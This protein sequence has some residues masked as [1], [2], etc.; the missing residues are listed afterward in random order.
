MLLGDVLARFDDEALAAETILHIGDLSLISKLREQA[1]ATGE[2]LG[3]YAASAMRRYAADA[4]DEE[5]VTLMGLLGRAED[6][7]AVCL[8]RAF[9]YVLKHAH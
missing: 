2:P 8:Q 4:S 6:P 7:G 9:A 5:W 1:D 3:A